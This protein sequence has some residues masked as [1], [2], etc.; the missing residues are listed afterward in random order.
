MKPQVILVI[1]LSAMGDV[2]LTLPVIRAVA[3]VE[4]E[5]VV[6]T[7]PIFAAF[8]DNIHNVSCFPVD[9]DGKYRGLAG[10]HKLYW[11]LKKNYQIKFV[12][13]LHAVIRSF[14]LTLLFRTASIRVFTIKK[15]RAQKRALV[16][17]KIMKQLPHTIER[18]STVLKRAGLAPADPVIPAFSLSDDEKKMANKILSDI[19]HER[20]QQF[21]GIAPFSKHQTKSWG[22]DKIYRLL[23]LLSTKGDFVFLLFGGREDI[24]GLKRI[25]SRIGSTHIVAGSYTLRIEL[26][27]ISKLKFMI[28]M[29]S[30]NMH[31]ASLA[32]VKTDSIW[33]GT[34]PYAGFNA[35]GQDPDLSIGIS[36]SAIDCRPC[37]VYGRGACIR[38]DI[39]FKCLEDVSA[40]EVL[41]VIMK[42]GLVR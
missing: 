8:F 28:S 17:K 42:A 15:G 1:R 6:I 3:S 41:K 31:L 27:L 7:R 19:E 18:Y 11:D 23:D 33:G 30:S 29:D 38:G 25:S 22:E 24:E 39:K 40:D 35:Y 5:I 16:K 36:P 13:D 14:I 10:I 21:I 9:T 2:A 4:N 32:G 34:H 20:E 37:T 26:A 12:I